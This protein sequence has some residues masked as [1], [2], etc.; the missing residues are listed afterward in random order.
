MKYIT[1]NNKEILEKL[2]IKCENIIEAINF[3]RTEK[4]K[5]YVPMKWW[6]FWKKD[7]FTNTFLLGLEYRDSVSNDSINFYCGL[8]RACCAN[9]LEELKFKTCVKIKVSDIDK[10][11]LRDI[12]KNLPESS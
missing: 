7:W 12:I 9:M 10:F 5:K 3:E 8:Q 1:I 4:L 11:Q 6:E 2:K